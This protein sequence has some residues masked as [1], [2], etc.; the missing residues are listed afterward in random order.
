MSGSRT[1]RPSVNINLRDIAGATGYSVTTVANG[2]SNRGR[3]SHKTRAH[4]VE[5]AKKLGYSPN[6]LFE[7]VR[8]GRSKT[9][10]VIVNL[11]SGFCAQISA[12]IVDELFERDYASIIM[13]NIVEVNK[14]LKNIHHLLERRIEGVVFRPQYGEARLDVFH[15]LVDRHL[16]MV[17]VDCAYPAAITDFVGTDDI[18]GGRIVA[19]YLLSLGHKNFGF[20]GVRGEFSGDR[21]RAG[22]EAA[23]KEYPDTTVISSQPGHDRQWG[24]WIKAISMQLLTANPR[25]TAIF[26]SN[27]DFALQIYS[28]AAELGIKIPE[29]LS[30]VGFSNA[31][32]SERLVPQLTTV[33]QDP[34]RIGRLA[35]GLLIDRLE[36]K[37]KE[38]VGMKIELQPNL[39]LR[40][41]AAKLKS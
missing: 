22:F 1:I 25:P 24:S 7:A 3:M 30:V 10:G 41:S 5:T 15:E 14:R 33:H 29:E 40:K 35:A 13:P 8:T 36:G 9:I 38:P 11:D 21:R 23:I 34:Y 37:G 19:E 20:C 31:D 39:V 18:M 2:L 26:A 17:A 27:D 12:G 16:P 6:A 4:I 32:W 28:D